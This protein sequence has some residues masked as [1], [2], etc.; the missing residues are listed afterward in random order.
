MSVIFLA[1]F[2]HFVQFQEHG[3]YRCG[4][5]FNHSGHVFCVFGDH[6]PYECGYLSGSPNEALVL[7]TALQQQRNH[8][9]APRSGPDSKNPSRL[10]LVRTL[11]S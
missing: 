1:V 2:L 4:L 7:S 9:H 5:L 6:G 3:A 8:L 11:Y 10:R